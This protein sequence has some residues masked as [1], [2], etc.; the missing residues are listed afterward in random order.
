MRSGF[1]RICLNKVNPHEDPENPTYT[2]RF[3]AV[4]IIHKCWIPNCQVCLAEATLWYTY[5][6]LW[7]ITIF[8]G[9]IHYKW[10]IFNSYIKL[11]EANP[12]TQR[13]A[14]HF[15]KVRGVSLPPN[16]RDHERHV[17]KINRHVSVVPV[18]QMQGPLNSIMDYCNDWVQ[19]RH[20]GSV[21]G[22]LL[23]LGLFLTCSVAGFNCFSCFSSKYA[24]GRMC[25]SHLIVRVSTLSKVISTDFSNKPY[26]IIQDRQRKALGIWE[27]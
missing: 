12:L 17:R 3:P 5:K 16:R 1:C 4:K 6:K 11:P 15:V 14:K 13:R 9:Q 24:V 21:R 20:W 18:S 10:T 23:L 19:G 2:W 26:K 8:N 7:K 27:F 25:W 22:K